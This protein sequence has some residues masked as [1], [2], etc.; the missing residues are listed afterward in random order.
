MNT[1]L[2]Q[3]ANEKNVIQNF[4]N[5]IYGLVIQKTRDNLTKPIYLYVLYS[6]LL[7]I[8]KMKNRKQGKFVR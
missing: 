4:N 6:C 1:L 8:H 5:D 2:T 7:K 3:F